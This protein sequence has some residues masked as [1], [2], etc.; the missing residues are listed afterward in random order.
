M[1]P[2]A[3]PKEELLNALQV[4]AQTGLTDAQA[5]KRLREAGENRLAEKKKKTNLQRF[6]EQFKD[7][8]ILILLLAAAVS[9]VVACTEGDPWNSLSRCSF[10]SLSCST[11]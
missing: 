5:E 8:M 11:P 9:F 10:W 3:M 2:H 1:T 4:Q 7:V 6:A